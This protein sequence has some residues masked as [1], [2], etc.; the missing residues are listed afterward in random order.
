V[1]PLRILAVGDVRVPEFGA[2]S[3][4]GNDA[5]VLHRAADANAALVALAGPE[6]YDAV[7]MSRDN[8]FAFGDAIEAIAALAALVVVG[9]ANR[10]QQAQAIGLGAE[11]VIAFEDLTMPGVVARLSLAVER[12]RRADRQH[13][14]NASTDTATGLPNRQ[15]FIEHL[16]QLAALR[17]R[18]PQ[19]MA[20]VAVRVM[21]DAAAGGA[22]AHVLR[23]KAAV[24][25]RAGVRASDVVAWV[26]EDVYAVL[27][28]SLLAPA[29]AER[30]A[31]KLETAL[32]A[33]MVVGGRPVHVLAATSIAHHPAD[34][35]EAQALLERAIARL[36]A[37]TDGG[38]ATGRAAAANDA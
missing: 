26:G 37:R 7:L 14:A 17:E 11:D 9:P 2:Q 33:P 10:E 3:A 31:A 32:A 4:V 6:A 22:E 24:R 25:L 28:G 19:P 23:R 36:E 21:G 34:G 38:V 12:K 35:T 18:E 20:V 5:M 30:V 13:A 29:D 1:T 16:S 27:L 15:Q 8:A